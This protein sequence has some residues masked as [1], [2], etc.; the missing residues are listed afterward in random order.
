MKD[1]SYIKLHFALVFII[2]MNGDILD[3][4]EWILF[5]TDAHKLDDR[6][7][8]IIIF[9]LFPSFICDVDYSEDKEHQHGD[10]REAEVDLH[11]AL[12]L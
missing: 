4:I 8:E 9:T 11:E 3:C 1:A 2:P 12:E 5:L 6:D 10:E 7:T